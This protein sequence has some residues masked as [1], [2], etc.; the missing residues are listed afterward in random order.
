MKLK[1]KLKFGKWW[2]CMMRNESCNYK[3]GHLDKNCLF[4]HLCW[5]QPTNPPT[6]QLRYWLQDQNLPLSKW[7]MFKSHLS[8]FFLFKIYFNLHIHFDYATNTN[9][10]TI[11]QDLIYPFNFPN[12]IFQPLSVKIFI[13]NHLQNK[14]HK[15]IRL[16]L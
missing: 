7:P 11:T 6:N 8:F 4:W 5:N 1:L 15:H 12:Q 16:Y 10:Q 14:V 9:V 13:S 2:W 3:L